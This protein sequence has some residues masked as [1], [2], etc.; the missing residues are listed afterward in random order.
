MAQRQKYVPKNINEYR[1]PRKCHIHNC[2]EE[3]TI[4]YRKGIASVEYSCIPHVHRT[5]AQV[6]KPGAQILTPSQLIA[7]LL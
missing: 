7:Q 2:S 6:T 5:N 4:S 1:L 3:G